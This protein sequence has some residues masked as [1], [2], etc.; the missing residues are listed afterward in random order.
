MKHLL[1]GLLLVCQNAL[2]ES[3]P[4][5]DVASAY[6]VQVNKQVLWEKQANVRLPPASLTKLMMA[7]LTLEKTPLN[8][9]VN[10]S[11]DATKE[12]GSRL[13]LQVNSKFSAEDLLKAALL[14]SANDACHALVDHVAGNEKEFVSLMNVR[15]RQMGLLGTHFQNACGHDADNHYSTANDLAIVANQALEHGFILSTVKLTDAKITS[16]DGR[17][18][19]QLTNKNALLG[20]YNGIAGLKTGYTAKAGKC[21]IAYATRNQKH[22]L[23]ILLNAPNRWWDAV[24][25]LNLA[26]SHDS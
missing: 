8:T 17:Y 20:R 18:S 12:T 11:Q 9:V 23:L 15:A 7:L 26:F 5:P 14:N 2:A 4:F 6:L 21:L 25:I 1:V 3:N 24:D 13:G 22:V 10:I 19:Y 16:P